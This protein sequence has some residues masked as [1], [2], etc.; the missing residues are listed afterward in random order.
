[1]T[2]KH[3]LHPIAL[4]IGIC[5]L[6]SA[7]D[8]NGNEKADRLNSLSYDFHYRNLDSTL[9]YADKAYEA[10]ARYGGGKAEAYNNKAFVSIV[11][12]DYERAQRQLDSIGALTDNQ[13]ELL[14]ADIQQMR[15]CQRQSRNKDFYTFRESALRRIKRID[16]EADAL[17]EHQEGRMVYARSEMAIVTSTYYYYV[18]LDEQSADAIDSI[19][20]NGN[21][22]NDNAQLLN[23]LYNIGAGGII[24]YG[25]QEEINQ[26]EL[27]Y[28]FRCYNIALQY[29]YPFWV[30][31]SLQAMSEHLQVP[32]MRQ[33][34]IHDN[35]STFRNINIDNMPDSLLAGN[36]A[37]RS[38][39]IFREYGDVYQTAG[40][41]RT[42]AQCYWQIGDYQAALDC[43]ND[44]L[45]N[46]SAIFK[47]P[48]LVASI[49]EQLSVTYAALDNKV[50]TM[51]NRNFYIDTQ[52]KTRQDLYLES[53]AEQLDKSVRQLNVMIVAIV[54]VMAL[55]VALL[56]LFSYLRRKE[57][58]RDPLSTL[59]LPL[60]EWKKDNAAYQEQLG[61]RYEETMERMAVCQQHIE[62][63]KRL[64]LEQRA[65]VSLVGMVTPYIDRILLEI[66]RLN[67][68]GEP[69]QRRQERYAYVA[70]L[71]DRIIEYNDILTQWIQLRKGELSLHIESFPI[72]AL[73]DIV[74]H[75]KRGFQMKELLL[76][77]EPSTAWV[78]ADRTLTLFMIN[79][80]ADNARKFTPAGGK[81]R[82][83]ATEADKY[84]EIS[85]SDTGIGMT[86][87]QMQEVFS[88]EKR[89]FHEEPADKVRM[90]GTAAKEQGHGFGLV[91][92]K[93]IIEK[94]KKISS[95]FSVCHIGVESEKG[96]GS[97]FFFRLPKGVARL[98]LA[99]AMT[100][101]GGAAMPTA[102]ATAL[103]ADSLL[104]RAKYHAVR[105]GQCNAAD[106]YADALAHADTA[107][108]C[109]NGAYRMLKPN[110]SDTLMLQS[111]KSVQQAEIFWFHDALPVDFD[112]IRSLRND[113]AVAAL[114]SHEWAIYRYNNKVYTQLYKEMSADRTLA[115]YCRMMQQ[116]QSNKYMAIVIL[117]ILSLLILMAYFF[118]FY[119]HQ[120]YYRF[121]LERVRA[122]NQVLR[123]D[124]NDADKLAEIERLAGVR[125]TDKGA[126]RGLRSYDNE[127]LPV[128]LQQVADELIAALK[129][130]I[131][132]AQR[133][134]EDIDIAEDEVRRSEMENAQLHV[135]NSV[136]DNCLSTLKHETMYYPSR[137]RTLVD[138][139]DEQLQSVSELA[140]YYKELYAIL[141]RQA[142]HQVE[143]IQLQC[144]PVPVS[145]LLPQVAVHPAV[146]AYKGMSLL[147]DRQMLRYLFALLRKQG[148]TTPPDIRV[149]DRADRYVDFH[150]VYARM[151]LTDEQC[152]NLFNP[153]PGNMP[154][155][156]CRQIVRD[157]GETTNARACGIRALNLGDAGVELVLTMVKAHH[158]G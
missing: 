63:S 102:A 130:S 98:L 50:E 74:A 93:G 132:D 25:T 23:Y 19:D 54:V 69:E 155:L 4:L 83:A 29:N 124:R 2:T 12:M 154:F 68:G 116:S 127:R 95:L 31:N 121:C 67:A 92:C 57:D 60:Q 10:S 123:A 152:H 22:L 87:E 46:D 84:V 6:V 118:I 139:Q 115:D 28:L 141:S 94:Y 52:D 24:S 107:I 5:F 15:L 110:G 17:N 105:V 43:L 134:M 18:G 120:V 7:C 112:C 150:V 78:K 99:W 38:L 90:A 37:Q 64:N 59:L 42:L 111:N 153:A 109:F 9:Y 44:A 128:M 114:A 117:I 146:E 86:P 20:P 76:E 53:R 11:R 65:K 104:A 126:R 122:M 136:L 140:H 34:L 145:E 75:G 39:N 49:R 16:E 106:R 135:C 81:V 32:V 3:I 89:A 77:V 51:R 147:G 82:V 62:N 137:I 100:M 41:Y 21:I 144:V 80:I 8:A 27:E 108:A 66:K 119:R 30:A 72:Q 131:A 13:V 157:V 79:T 26:V 45:Y 103:S 91:N 1:M 40:S 148:G 125:R 14:I 101:A 129:A 143:S 33:K 48:D 36:L 47:A 156:L 61:E 158:R 58:R 88:V 151:R 113:I 96:K 70:E 97:R 55:G 142:M 149:V 133:R 85:V 35:Y 73:F 138:Q 71:A 56:F